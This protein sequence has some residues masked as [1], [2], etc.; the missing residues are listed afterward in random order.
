MYEQ[1]T[2][3]MITNYILYYVLAL[4]YCFRVSLRDERGGGGMK[5]KCC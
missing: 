3:I 5:S 2:Y 1:L 4:L